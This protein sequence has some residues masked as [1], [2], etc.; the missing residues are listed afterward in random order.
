MAPDHGL[1]HKAK[2]YIRRANIP[3]PQ[4]FYSYN[5]LAELDPHTIFQEDFIRAVNLNSFMN[6]AENHYSN[7]APA[8]DTD[9]LLYLD[10]KFTITDNDIRKVTQMVEAAGLRVRYPVLDRDLVDFTCT[11]P[12]T[13]KV[14]WKKNR[15]IFKE[16]M[17][18]FLPNEII[19]KSKHGMGLPVTPWFKQERQMKAL[20]YDI[21]FS[22]TPAMTRYIKPEFIQKMKTA[23][24]TDASTYYGDNLWVF[25]I[26]EMWLNQGG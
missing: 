7:A 15:Y 12:P 24:E 3:N 25:L 5:L 21:L 1:L 10:M 8:D 22:G 23:F 13:L 11:I 26:L 9:R 14:K 16:A 20:L 4:R 18:G 6:I 17:K 19:T 2:S